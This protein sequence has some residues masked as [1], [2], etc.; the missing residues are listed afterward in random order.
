MPTRSFSAPHAP[1]DRRRLLSDHKRNE[2]PPVIRSYQLRRRGLSNS[3]RRRVYVTPRA[4]SST[5]E[6]IA[7][8]VF[9]RML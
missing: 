8:G 2:A 3:Q 9:G 5:P 7:F 4:H 1:V 6:Q